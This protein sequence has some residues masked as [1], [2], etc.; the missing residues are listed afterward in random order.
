MTAFI[1]RG[2]GGTLDWNYLEDVRKEWDGPIVIKGK[3]AA[4]GR[5]PEK[6]L[7]IL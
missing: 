4:I 7:D 5:P 3:K 2:L 1:G 6:V